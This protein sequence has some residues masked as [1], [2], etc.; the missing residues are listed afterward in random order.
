MD[1]HTP[2]CSDEKSLD[3]DNFCYPDVEGG[4][5]SSSSAG[6]TFKTTEEIISE[7]RRENFRLRLMCFDY[8]KARKRMINPQDAESSRLFSVEAENLTLKEVLAEKTNLLRSAS[9]TIDALKEEN[10]LL[11]EKLHEWE[12]KLHENNTAWRR[13]YDALYLQLQQAKNVIQSFEFQSS[14]HKRQDSGHLRDLIS[15]ISEPGVSPTTNK[16]EADQ[17][18]L[19]TTRLFS[20]PGKSSSSQQRTDKGISRLDE[21]DVLEVSRD[22]HKSC[23]DHLMHCSLDHLSSFILFS[24]RALA[25]KFHLST[26]RFSQIPTF[27]GV[28]SL[29]IPAQQLFDMLTRSFCVPATYSTHTTLYQNSTLV[30]WAGSLA[31]ANLTY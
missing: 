5:N 21:I 25:H 13:Q 1:P 27:T 16:T 8:E 23:Q 26:E 18:Q 22:I 2:G 29:H 15:H 17:G 11:N 12:E 10:N 31:V 30:A 28:L 7:L 9:K 3:N 14:T 19:K 24:P 20:E 6:G 4:F